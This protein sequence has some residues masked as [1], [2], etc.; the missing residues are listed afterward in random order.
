M[1]VFGT[2]GATRGGPSTEQPQELAD[3]ELW[4]GG[5]AGVA[6]QDPSSLPGARA[7]TGFSGHGTSTMLTGTITSLTTAHALQALAGED[8]LSTKY[9]RIHGKR[10]G[11]I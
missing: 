2:Q 10:S 8:S 7:C 11:R 3:I 1:Y 4:P 6:S 5:G 9:A